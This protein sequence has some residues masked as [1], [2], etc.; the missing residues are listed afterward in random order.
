MGDEYD[1]DNDFEDDYQEVD[2]PE[3][4]EEIDEGER[5]ASWRFFLNN[6]LE[7]FVATCM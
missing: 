3:E 4:M 5:G 1:N 7:T 2:E 6:F